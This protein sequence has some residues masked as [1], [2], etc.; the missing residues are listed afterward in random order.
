MR[1]MVWRPKKIKIRTYHVYKREIPRQQRVEKGEGWY[2]QRIG[3]NHDWKWSALDLLVQT[4]VKCQVWKIQI[5]NQFTS[6]I[7]EWYTFNSI[8]LIP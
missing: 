1:H 8:G 7:Y 4:T 5:K 3:D 2:I 6:T